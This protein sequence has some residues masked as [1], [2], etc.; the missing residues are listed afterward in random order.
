MTDYERVA[1]VIRHLDESFAEQPDLRQ[2][3]ERVGLSPSH[4]QRLFTRW[5]G[6][7]PK[8]F[9]Q[10]VTFEHARGLLRG[11]G[12]VLEVALDSGL[13][14]PGRLH[15]LTVKLEAAT[16]GEIKSGGDGWVMR[17]GFAETPFG[18]AVIADNPR[19]LCHLAFGDDESDDDMLAWVAADWPRATLKRDDAM[20]AEWVDRIFRDGSGELKACVRATP[21]QLQVWRALLRVPSGRLVSY[22]ELSADVGR[23][24]AARAVG[25][26]VGSNRISYLIPCHRV[27]RETG[28]LGGYRWGTIRK[29]AMIARESLER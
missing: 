28:A 19:G 12:N 25:T 8:A 23:P 4:F 20:A 11:G 26:A 14:G 18:R 10:C 1:A 29:R 7:S 9:L 6:V 15:D 21:F 24:K 16:P 13:S 5:A 3:A 17:A 27:I 2:L 22:G